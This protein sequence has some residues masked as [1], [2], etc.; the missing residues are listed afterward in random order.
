LNQEL[1]QN[2]FLQ[3]KK[4]QKKKANQAE[5]SSQAGDSINGSLGD[6]SLRSSPGLD[7]R[8]GHALNER[9]SSEMEEVTSQLLEGHHD[10]YVT[11][12]C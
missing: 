1:R 12:L 10:P 3:L 8:P 11:W 9:R 4:F 2:Q 7:I 5:T 6:V